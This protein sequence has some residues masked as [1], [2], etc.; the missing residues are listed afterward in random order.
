MNI[1]NVFKRPVF[2]AFFCLLLT[3]ISCSR[4]QDERFHWQFSGQTMGTTYH[5]KALANAEVPIEKN[6]L[7]SDIDNALVAFNQAMSTY[8]AD[9]ELSLF[10]Q[11]EPGEW[12]SVSPQLMSV[13]LISHSVSEAS[14]GAFDVTVGP[15]VNAWGFGPAKREGAPSDSE[16]AAA[17]QEVGYRF[18][19]LDK[20]AMKIRKTRQI[21]VDLS[22][23]A[24]GYATDVIGELIE[25][26]GIQSYMV[27]IGG[28][29]KIKGSNFAGSPWTIGVEKPALGHDGTMQKISGNDVGIATSGD[30]R[31]FYEVDGKR[32]SHTL[33]PQTGKPI[34]H[35]LASI[36]VIAENGGQADAYATAINVLGPELGYDLATKQKLAAF[37]VVREGEGF[38]TKHTPEFEQYMVK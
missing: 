23:V 12:V 16:I 27:E 8:I 4:Q 3:V 32:V 13:L 19:E 36:T 31:N 14:A 6:T 18:L 15:L 1:R 34:T 38:T 17:M 10:N 21:Y 2:L 9:S 25:A 29:L 24:K 22:A 28:E 11:S 33:N 30:Y 20:A 26:N 37:F 5:I 7:A 35:G